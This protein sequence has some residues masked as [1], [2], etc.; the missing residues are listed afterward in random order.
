VAVH[1]PFNI[2]PMCSKGGQQ[3]SLIR[4]I[5]LTF[6]KQWQHSV[7]MDGTLKGEGKSIFF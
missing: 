4:N 1:N 5:P 2:A 6:H 7:G 3:A